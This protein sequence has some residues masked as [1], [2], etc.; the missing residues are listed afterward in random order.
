M[1]QDDV[2]GIAAPVAVRT[3]RGHGQEPVFILIGDSQARPDDRL[4]AYKADAGKLHD[5]FY[6]KLPSTTYVAL[7]REFMIAIA[8]D[9]VSELHMRTDHSEA[10]AFIER[11]DRALDATSKECAPLPGTPAL[12]EVA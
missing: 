11:I 12:D 8:E 5:L 1:A 7:I 2:S 3:L 10:L 9:K 4:G 6:S